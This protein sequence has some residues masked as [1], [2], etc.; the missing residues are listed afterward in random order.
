MQFTILFLFIWVGGISGDSDFDALVEFRKGIQEDPSGR[1]IDS[2]NPSSELDSFGCPI[3]WYG[4]QCSAGR[5]SSIALGNVGL[6]G[7][8]SFSALTKMS[9]LQNLSLSNNQLIGVLPPEMGLISSL[10]LLDLSNNLF[11]GP[12]PAQLTK[13]VNLVYLNLSSNSFS[14]VLPPGFQNFRKLK[15]LDLQ[16]NNFS[17]K[18]DEVFAELQGLVDI[19]FSRNQ[20]SGSLKSISDDSAIT[21]SLRYLN[22]SHNGLSGELF[23][24]GSV[25]LFDS[26]EVFDVSFNQ[27]SGNVP[28]FNFIVS[29]RILRLRENQFSGSLPEALF[30]ETSMVLTELD[31]SCNQLT[32]PIKRVTSITLK[33][34]NLSFNNLSGSLPITVGSCAVIDLS[35]N[36]LSGNLS[37]IRA[38][39][40]YVEVIDLSSNGLTGILPNETSQF[41]RLASFNVS[42]NLLTGELPPV[43]GTYPELSAIDLSLNQLYG[44]LP[45]TLFTSVR[46]SILNL[47][48]NSFTGT[49]PFPDGEGALP[50]SSL[51]YLDLSKNSLSGPLPPEIG[52]LSGL[53]LLNIGKN[54]FSGQIPKEI[55]LLQNLQYVD[56]SSNELDG[57]IPSGFTDGLVGFNVSYNNLSGNVPNNLL[58]FPYSSFHPGNELLIFP[59][60]PPSNVSDLPYKGR[61]HDRQMKHTLQ[62]VLIGCA[63]ACFVL[64]IV[65]VIIH[66]RI[67]GQKRRGSATDKTNSTITRCVEGQKSIEPP[68]AANQDQYEQG[69]VSLPPKTDTGESSAKAELFD[70]PT[71]SNLP[72][73][74]YEKAST[75]HF[76]FSP[77]P[78]PSVHQH[79]S[80]LRVYS[81]DKLAGDLHLFNSSLV[82][83][84]EELSQAPAEIIGRSCHG[85]SYKATLENGH[86]LIV[87]WLKEGLAKSKK[88]FGREVKKLGNIKH[89][90]LVSLRGYYWGPREHERILIS[91]YIDAVSLTT[92][93]CNFRERNLSPLSLPQRLNIAIDIA[94][95]LN[96][97]H[98]EMA[99]PHGNLKSSN[100][101]IQN[102]PLPNALVT[103]YSLHRLMTPAGMAEQVL[104]AGALG[105]RPPEFASTNKP[106]PSI[107]SDVYAFGVVLLELL[108]GKSAGE[109][110]SESPGVVDLIDWARLLA[111]EDRAF[112][113]F[114]RLLLEA[115]SSESSSKVLEDLLRVALRCIR[116][117]SERPEIETV[118]EDLSA[119]SS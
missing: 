73:K 11:S 25:P 16:G 44:P 66:R 29:L 107:K 10:E 95:C 60:S 92:Y 3:N 113:C 55:G 109:I 31:L 46:L 86:V 37:V 27:L 69:D 32:G 42:N 118:F 5:V 99:I 101:L 13:L 85:T 110:V 58:K 91:D 2:W 48:G 83:T 72:Q 77:P 70:R 84:A 74:D 80:I 30:R 18:V 116:S 41:L 4:V 9:M 51:T 93:L 14:G 23:L 53:K 19:D 36:M 112:E 115:G 81:P 76:A 57:T 67:S 64:I 7:N 43:I 97:L 79:P 78:D 114:D 26:L 108:T 12:I 117:A 24:K 100:I 65:L 56:L 63:F 88:E 49:I 68:P 52:R 20:F 98:N 102:V 90:N 15:Y 21:S 75:S 6:V 105:Y 59:S 38:W 104:N 22:V 39:G 17:G 61:K 40:N 71:V 119:L 28:S 54:N 45:S 34:L 103:D 82:F 62:Y 111:S 87:K 50:Y 89:Q 1:I 94:R 8:I 35:N 106:C 33:S 47:S 96:Y